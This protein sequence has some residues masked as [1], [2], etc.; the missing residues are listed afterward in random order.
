MIKQPSSIFNDVIG[1]VMRGSS[2]SHVAASVRIGNLIRQISEGHPSGVRVEF[3]EEGSLATTYHGHGSDMGFAGGLLGFE[4]WDERLPA[5]LSLINAAGI[6]L[7]FMITDY[8]ADHPNNY[9]ITMTKKSEDDI[10]LDAVSTGGGMIEIWNIEGHSVSIAGD[11]FETMLFMKNT[12]KALNAVNTVKE[13]I[14]DYDYIDTDINDDNILINIKTTIAVDKNIIKKLCNL[15]DINRFICLAPVLPVMSSK[16]ATVPFINAEQMLELGEK[17]GMELWELAILY[18]SCRGG[19]TKDEVYSKM[20]DVVALMENAI[21]AGLSGTVYSDR[22]LGQQSHL[23]Q[24]TE[25]RLIPGDVTNTI[26]KYVTAIMETKSSMGIIIAA[27][28][29]GAAGGLPGTII[30]AA[31]VMKL[32]M[33]MKIKAMLCAGIIGVFISEKSGFAAET[34]GCQVECGAGSGMA[35]AGLVMLAG[36]TLRQCVNASS[37][38]LQNILGMVCDPVGDRVEVPCLGKN[39]MAGANAVVCANMA[40]SGFDVVVPLDETLTAMDEVGKM[41]PAELRCTNKGGLS[42]TKASKQIM[43]RLEDENAE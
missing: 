26:I 41:L 35:A 27:P 7:R 19:I 43:K 2:S 37:M 28:T 25:S 20:K 10:H 39:V 34:G 22:I 40:L 18:E 33:D 17:R 31:D 38:A 36:G 15:F 16:N 11:F 13:F 3:T 4:P 1:P 30:G 29:A 6:D 8:K 42:L 5:S 24:K 14:I 9:R 32:D 12:D 21:S 23:I